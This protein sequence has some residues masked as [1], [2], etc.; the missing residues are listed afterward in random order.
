M[1]TFL[2]DSAIYTCIF[3]LFVF[4]QLIIQCLAHFVSIYRKFEIVQ[5]TLL[6][7]CPSHKPKVK[8]DNSAK[9]YESVFLFNTTLTRKNSRIRTTIPI[10]ETNTLDNLLK[11]SLSNLSSFYT[12]FHTDTVSAKSINFCFF[13]F[14]LSVSEYLFYYNIFSVMDKYELHV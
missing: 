2:T 14:F 12:F 11:L 7:A 10:F 9:V 3:C 8:R 5:F 1:V 4:A 6:Y 13:L